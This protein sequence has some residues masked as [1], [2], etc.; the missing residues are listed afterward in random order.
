MNSSVMGTVISRLWSNLKLAE[1]SSSFRRPRPRPGLMSGLTTGGT[2]VRSGSP[3]NMYWQN[4]KWDREGGRPAEPLI[5]TLQVIEE[6]SISSP[7]TVDEFLDPSDEDSEFVSHMAS[8]SWGK[9]PPVRSI[10]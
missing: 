3:Q 5:V 7:Q 2:T 6:L 10:W 1:S 4:T 8:L 9:E